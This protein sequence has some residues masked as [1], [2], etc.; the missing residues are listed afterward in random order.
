MTERTWQ[1]SDIDGSNKRTVTLAQFKAENRAKADAAAARY[2]HS[3]WSGRKYD[4]PMTQAELIAESMAV[5][6][7]HPTIGKALVGK[8]VR[9]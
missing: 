1:I 3:V 2:T 8:A 5:L 4:R 9:S 7:R 6:R